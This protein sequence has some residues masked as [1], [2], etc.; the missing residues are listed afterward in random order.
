VTLRGL[1]DEIRDAFPNTNIPAFEG[2]GRAEVLLSQIS[3]AKE[4]L[5]MLTRSVSGAMVPAF[6]FILQE[7]RGP[8]FQASRA[9]LSDAIQA[10]EAQPRRDRDSCANAYDTM[11]SAAKVAFNMP[12]AT[13]GKV[14]NKANTRLD[15]CTISS[16]R[17]LETLRHQKFG[18]GTVTPFDLRAAEVDY[19][20]FA[21]LSG[22]TLFV[23]LA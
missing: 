23:R 3:V 12:D 4:R 22:A 10:Y 17:S 19:V 15:A 16:L 6:E 9:H 13:L 21:C 20:F 2:H 11:E 5:F 14:L 18:H 1:F 7:F 8:Q